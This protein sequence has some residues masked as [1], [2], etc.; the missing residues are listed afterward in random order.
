[1]FTTSYVNKRQIFHFWIAFFHLEF[2][3]NTLRQAESV[4]ITDRLLYKV[5]DV[6]VSRQSYLYSMKVDI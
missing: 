2:Y 4:N 3:F 6:K 5:L 1:M